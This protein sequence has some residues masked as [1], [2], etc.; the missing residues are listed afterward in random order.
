MH[1]FSQVKNR[2]SVLLLTIFQECLAV[3]RNTS[4]P[5]VLDEIVDDMQSLL[6]LVKKKTTFE[7]TV[8]YESY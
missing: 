2:T 1:I 7:K 6:N 8:A 4:L 3:R 5:F